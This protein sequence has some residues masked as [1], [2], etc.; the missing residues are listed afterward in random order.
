M[1]RHARFHGRRDPE[2]HV[3]AGEVLVHEVQ[4]KRRQFLSL[5]AP[6]SLGNA[7]LQVPAPKGPGR[8]RFA[9][10]KG[11]MLEC[12]STMRLEA[13]WRRTIIRPQAPSLF[14]LR[15]PPPSRETSQSLNGAPGFR[16]RSHNTP[17]PRAASQRPNAADDG[18]SQHPHSASRSWARF[19]ALRSFVRA[20]AC[21]RFRLTE[22]FS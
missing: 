18:Q 10:L 6:K 1:V 12:P 2:R 7:G 17:S 5:G 16:V 21:F 9:G 15:L 3:D 19:I 14:Q 20:R 4:R 13:G 22:G 8:A 11:I